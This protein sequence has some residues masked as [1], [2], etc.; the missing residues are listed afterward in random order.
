MDNTYQTERG[1]TVTFNGIEALLDKLR[2]SYPMPAKPRY[3]IKSN[4]TGATEWFDH[5]ETTLDVPNDPIQSAANHKAMT[6][7]LRQSIEAQNKYFAA[8]TRTVLLYGVNV[9]MP[10]DESWVKRQELLGI[11]VPKDP[12]E[13]EMHWRET[14]LYGSPD[15]LENITIG[16]MRAGGTD[17]ETLAAMADSFRHSLGQ[18]KRDKVDGVANTQN[19]QGVVL[20]SALGTSNH[21]VRDG[22]TAKPVRRSKRRR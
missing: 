13:R 8:I 3:S 15:D 16:V 7:Y 2:A 6:E 10:K 20:Q 9:E 18:P 1:F 14:E 17:E 22:N 19:G 11:A 4:L 12:L 5:D 21:T